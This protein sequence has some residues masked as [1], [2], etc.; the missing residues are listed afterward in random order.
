MLIIFI[1][2]CIA[3]TLGKSQLPAQ[4][5]KKQHKPSGPLHIFYQV[6]KFVFLLFLLFS[7]IFVEATSKPFLHSWQA[8][9]YSPR[10]VMVS[11]KRLQQFR[12]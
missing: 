6:N 8:N 7:Q 1:W 9:S 2:F 12:K 5:N 3:G 4:K 11:L 10:S